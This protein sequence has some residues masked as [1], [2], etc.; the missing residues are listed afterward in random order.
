MNKKDVFK[1]VQNIILSN[2]YTLDNKITL[3]SDLVKDL[4]LDSLD[5]T[6]IIMHIEEEFG[7]SIP[8]EIAENIHTVEQLVNYIIKKA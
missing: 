1:K 7:I 5:T 3:E 2:D 6:D 4:G 8:D